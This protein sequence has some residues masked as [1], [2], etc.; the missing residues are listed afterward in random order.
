MPIA[1]KG[2]NLPAATLHLQHLSEFDVEL[3]KKDKPTSSSTKK[4]VTRKMVHILGQN[5]RSSLPDRCPTSK[6]SRRTNGWN[7]WRNPRTKKVMKHAQD[8]RG[9]MDTEPTLERQLGA[10]LWV[11]Y[12]NGGKLEES[13]RRLTLERKRWKRADAPHSGNPGSFGSHSGS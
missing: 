8:L 11:R 7:D 4:I 9:S 2:R 12:C 5:T 10:S 13:L 3:S 6:T 1:T